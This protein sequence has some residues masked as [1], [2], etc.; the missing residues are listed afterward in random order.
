[1]ATDPLV[2]TNSPFNYNVGI[3]YESWT[4]GRP[5]RS[6]SADL[7]AVTQNFKLIRTYHDVWS[8][9]ATP[10]LDGTQQEVINYVLAHS[11]LQLAFGTQNSAL[12]QGG[13]GTAWTA[14]AMT[15]STYTDQWAQMLITAFG[16]VA[17]VQ[18]NVAVIL[19]GNELDS[20]GPP[21]TD[22]AFPSY[23]GWINSAF[24]NLTTSLANAGLGSIPIS[25]TIANYPNVSISPTANPIAVNTTANIVNNWSAGWNGGSPFVLF[26]QYT[27]AGT[28]PVPAP[29]TTGEAETTNYQPVIDYFNLVQSEITAV[30][31]GS[32]VFV[33][34][35]GY[36]S[37]WNTASG[38]P[39]AGSQAN[40]ISQIFTWLGNQYT[41]SNKTLPL[42]IF[43]A[44]DQPAQAD[45][46][47]QYYGIYN[48]NPASGLK[49]GITLPSWTSQLVGTQS[50]TPSHD[51]INGGSGNDSV[52]GGGGN[53]IINGGAGHNTA[54]FDGKAASYAIRIAA[55]SGTLTVQDKVGTEGAD[56]LTNFQNL[57]FGDK[58]IVA[59]WIVKAASLPAG[60][61]QQVV[62]LYTA[63]LGRAPDALGLDYYASR[64]ADGASLADIS[65]AFFN[66]V[67]AAP[68]YQFPNTDPAF[69]TL[70]YQTALG[71]AP[72]A[73]GLAYWLGELASGH[74]ARTDLVMALIAGAR[75]TGGNAADAQYIAN[76]E[77]VGAHFALTQGLTDVAW[78]RTV[79]SAVNGTAAS[80]TA[81][82]AQ[83]DAF[84][85]MAAASAT[86]ELTIQITGIVP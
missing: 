10:V 76:K 63:G 26:N 42:F 9:S 78:A 86:T 51:T 33:G 28:T 11:G 23:Q 49:T 53:D 82:N 3:D 17:A 57:Q 16:S 20:N 48:S 52:H 39:G 25:T 18:Q 59:S 55:G 38:G 32:E 34:E 40:V 44:F 74:L 43:D 75:G 47:Q 41:A 85:A 22:P 14:G 56:Q 62:D 80:V 61:I 7:D 15:S 73:P 5:N 35:T 30:K 13:F 8:G 71:R 60:Q 83:T 66:S 36:S 2:P 72:D 79:E 46:V 58:T 69:V 84:A 37:Y 12:A 54:V 70:V 27:P 65:R 21:S 68:I 64:L 6:I 67:E 81:A 4:S 77:A 19:L 50:G 1:M 31:A 29:A 24:A 45:V